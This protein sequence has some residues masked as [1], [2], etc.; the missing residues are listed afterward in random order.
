MEGDADPEAPV[1]RGRSVLEGAFRLLDVLSRAPA[2]VGLS[3]LSRE[4]GM[5]K[6]SAYRLVEQLVDLAAVQR[7]DRRY[8]VG[9]HL[10]RLGAAWQPHPVLQG[11]AR[12]PVRALSALTSSVAMVTVLREDRVRAVSAMRGVV[13]EVPRIQPYDEFPIRSAAG[14]LLLLGSRTAAD[15]PPAGFAE[16]E[17]RCAVK[18]FRR[19]G[20]VVVDHQEVMPGVCCVAAPVRGPGGELVAAVSALVLKPVLPAGLAELV[21]RAA[22]EVTR[23]LE[24][25]MSVR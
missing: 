9:P 16:D 12:D 7:D 13:K 25:A 14:R 2:G 23:N 19:T 21:V 20:S 22:R 6:A 5:P 1:D 17:W 24:L 10:A 15:P 3:E 8:F 18:S 4:A 11:A